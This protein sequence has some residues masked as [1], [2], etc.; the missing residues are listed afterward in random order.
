MTYLC[1][2]SFTSY[3]KWPGAFQAAQDTISSLMLSLM[4][5]FTVWLF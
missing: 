1:L 3:G 5:A 2:V 4:R